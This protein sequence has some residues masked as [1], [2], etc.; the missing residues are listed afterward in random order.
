M[1]V[2]FQFLGV[3]ANEPEARHPARRSRGHHAELRLPHHIFNVLYL[4]TTG[5]NK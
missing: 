1:T 4:I 2:E 3:P 5:T